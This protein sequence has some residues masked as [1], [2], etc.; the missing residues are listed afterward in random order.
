MKLQAASAVS[1]PYHRQITWFLDN[2]TICLGIPDRPLSLLLFLC[3]LPLS[4][5]LF[6]HFSKK[7]WHFSRSTCLFWTFW[8]PHAPEMTWFRATAHEWKLSPPYWE[9]VNK[10]RDYVDKF[11]SNVGLI[12]PVIINIWGK[13]GLHPLEYSDCLTDSPYFRENLHAHEKELD[14]TSKA[15]KGLISDCK[16]LLAAARSKSFYLRYRSGKPHRRNQYGYIYF[17]SI[18]Q[19]PLHSFNNKRWPK[20]VILYEKSSHKSGAQMSTLTPVRSC[21]VTCFENKGR[22]VLFLF[23]CHP[24]PHLSINLWQVRACDT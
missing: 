1:V 17:H 3:F 23:F 9:S 10:R 21:H 16:E 18:L 4:C 11:R 7:I 13:M 24:G 5:L 15:I 19:D 8:R 2:R 14:R 6:R 22:G 12:L 20:S